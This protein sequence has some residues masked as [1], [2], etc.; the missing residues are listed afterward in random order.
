MWRKKRCV[1]GECLGNEGG[2]VLEAPLS[3]GVSLTSRSPTYSQRHTHSS[4]ENCSGACVSEAR[5]FS[6]DEAATARGGRT[7]LYVVRTCQ[8]LPRWRESQM[9]S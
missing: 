9:R 1:L 5:S 7:K 8:G 4:C 3:D 6:H 2:E